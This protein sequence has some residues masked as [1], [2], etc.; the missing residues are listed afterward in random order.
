MNLIDL[1]IVVKDPQGNLIGNA[2]ATINTFPD[3]NTIQPNTRL[4]GGGSCN[5]YHGPALA[6]PTH[7]NVSIVAA[8]FAPWCTDGNPLVF[9]S[10]T[11][12]KT[13]VLQPSFKRPTRDRVCAVRTTF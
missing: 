7:V 2:I 8:G 6:K 9:G 3:Q 13:V 5:F 11:V 4:I 12:T 10:E 1:N